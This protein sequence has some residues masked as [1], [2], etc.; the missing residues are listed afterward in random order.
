MVDCSRNKVPGLEGLP[1]ELY[2]SMLDFFVNLLV[3][4]FVNWQ[5]N[6][7]IPR[8]VCQGVVTLIRRDPNKGYLVDNFQLST[9]LNTELEIL[10]KALVKR[11][12]HVTDQHVRKAQTCAVP[13]RFIQDCLHLYT[14]ERINS[15]SGTLPV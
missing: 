8:S 3:S 9:L 5:Q 12:T 7:F 11:L 2:N 14:L 15:K 1:Y 4:V 13:G 10:V 6:R